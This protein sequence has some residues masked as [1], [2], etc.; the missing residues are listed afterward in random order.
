MPLDRL[1][2]EALA[3]AYAEVRG[4]APAVGDAYYAEYA[5]TTDQVLFEGQSSF[6]DV[7][8]AGERD[9][10]CPRLDDL[11]ALAE[12]VDD[13]GPLCLNHQS[14]RWECN[15]GFDALPPSTRSAA[16]GPTPEAAVAAWLLDRAGFVLA[17]D[18]RWWRAD[19]VKGP[20]A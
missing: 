14:C 6:W 19:E 12:E 7:W 5:E 20:P 17:D 2:C 11:L 8:N 16:Y 15:E 18:G 1:T 3:R 4:H 10:W 13:M 9:V